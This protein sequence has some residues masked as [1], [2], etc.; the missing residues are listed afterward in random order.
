MSGCT[1][2][3]VDS[4]QMFYLLFSLRSGLMD[5]RRILDVGVKLGLGTGTYTYV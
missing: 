2:A 3:L 1:F 4:N 5:A